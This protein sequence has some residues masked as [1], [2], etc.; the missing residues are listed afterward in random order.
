MSNNFQFGTTKEDIQGSS[1]APRVKN[2]FLGTAVLDKV[3]KRDIKGK[4]GTIYPNV[5]TF[6]WKAIKGQKDI[7]GNDVSGHTI[8]KTEWEPREDDDPGKVSNK[9]G[10]IGYIMSKHLSEEA[11]LIDGSQIKS[12]EHF[13]DTVVKRF[14]QA[15][16]RDQKI[17][18]KYP[19]NEYQGEVSLQ[20]P[21]Y[22][23]FIQT[24]GDDISLSFTNSEEQAN[25]KFMATKS[26]SPDSSPEAEVEVDD[27]DDLF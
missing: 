23:G 24:K 20:V 16:Y 11:A 26:L 2:P 18:I 27:D 7:A 19:A 14:E 6:V 25:A 21:N 13:V 15:D 22:K 10:R 1:G 5:L 17:R 8:E 3:E 9:T 12:W 4:D